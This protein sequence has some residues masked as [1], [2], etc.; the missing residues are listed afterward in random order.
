M[1]G[2]IESKIVALTWVF[3]VDSYELLY[4]WAILGGLW[5]LIQ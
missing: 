2:P 4:A 5:I 1:I 3:L